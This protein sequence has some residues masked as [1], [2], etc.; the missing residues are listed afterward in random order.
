LSNFYHNFL[1]RR[2]PD[3]EHPEKPKKPQKKSEKKSPQ[4]KSPEFFG[5]AKKLEANFKSVQGFKISQRPQ[6]N[7]S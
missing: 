6:S 5:K 1:S 4:K 3:H 2:N 7:S